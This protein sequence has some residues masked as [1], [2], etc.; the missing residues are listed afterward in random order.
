MK[1]SI[2]GVPAGPGLEVPLQ[3]AQYYCLEILLS[4]VDHMARR[5]E[6]VRLSR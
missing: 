6:G 2:Y 1:K 3:N 4:A 5:A